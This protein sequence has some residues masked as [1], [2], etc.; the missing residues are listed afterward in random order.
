MANPEKRSFE[1]LEYLIETYPE[2]LEKKTTSGDTPLMIAYRLGRLGYA[3]L[4]IKANADQSTRNTKGENIIHAALAGLPSAHRLR[5]LLEL[6]D[7]DLRGHLFQQRN[8]L[9]ENGLTPLHAWVSSG[10]T[11]GAT[12][13]SY[14]HTSSTW[15]SDASTPVEVLKLLLEY[16]Q[17]SELH[18]L[19]AVGETPL[20][21]IIMREQLATAKVLVDF[22]PKLLYRENAVGRT[23]AEV[24]HDLVSA[25]HLHKPSEIPSNMRRF[26][27]KSLV[28]D[29]PASFVKKNSDMSPE[30][31][32]KM[33]EQLGLS[34]EY[35][36]FEL[37]Q[38]SQA[39]GLKKEKDSVSL[40]SHEKK[41]II[42]DLCSTAMEKSP[43]LRRLVSLN[44][45]NDVAKR[46]G[47]TFTGSRYFTIQARA[48][49]HEDGEDNKEA[50]DSGDF[51]NRTFDGMRNSAW[52]VFTETE[53]KEAGLKKCDECDNYHE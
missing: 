18:L 13:Y 44:E 20:H 48:D 39:M 28:E 11:R 49:D 36:G 22:Q 24:A 50:E 7:P 38:I 15:Y 41:D 14:Y 32:K 47:E 5:P 33:T 1:L 46:L 10:D 35:T 52:K 2:S 42:W 4:L 9:Q 8:S 6:I 53:A 34:S 17:G 43:E 30:E 31:I 19:S 3:K 23:P 12:G 37:L 27:A 26:R 16:S 21:T 51:A 45:A 40:T 25:Q 29:P